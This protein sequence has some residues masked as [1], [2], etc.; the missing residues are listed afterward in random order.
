MKEKAEE[1]R[2]KAEKYALENV[3][4]G[5]VIS[6]ED[7]EK[8]L[9]GFAQSLQEQSS[10]SSSKKAEELKHFWRRANTI[11]S[12]DPTCFSIDEFTEDWINAQSLQEEKQE[13]EYPASFG[14]VFI[15]ELGIYNHPYISTNKGSIELS[16][17]ID[18]AIKSYYHK[19]IKETQ[20]V[21]SVDVEGFLRSKDIEINQIIV[22]G[23]SMETSKIHHIKD[24]LEEYAQQ[25]T[26]KEIK[27]PSEEE[28]EDL[29]DD[30]Q[31][32]FSTE[33]HEERHWFIK[34]VKWA[35]EETKKINK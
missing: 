7:I 15:N 11:Q 27:F 33:E 20:E 16:E 32:L 18:E 23:K 31:V 8:L 19:E 29:I 25:H 9:V 13:V 34:G 14:E 6:W 17:L 24:L 5:S 35:I 3:E 12:I 22:V 10:K 4:L 30:K 1:I 26:Q 21:E 28:I 2:K